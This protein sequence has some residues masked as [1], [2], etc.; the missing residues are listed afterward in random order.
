MKIIF[1]QERDNHVDNDSHRK[2]SMQQGVEV[3]VGMALV[4]EGR[5]EEPAEEDKGD[6]LP[7]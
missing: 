2:Y 5:T 4:R 3:A 6:K 1:S 7:I